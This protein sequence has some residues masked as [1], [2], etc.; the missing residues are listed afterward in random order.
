MDF[1]SFAMLKT[2]LMALAVGLIAFSLLDFFGIKR[3]A[4]SF[5]NVGRIGV[6]LIG[7]LLLGVGMQVNMKI[8]SIKKEKEME[9]LAF[10]K[11]IFLK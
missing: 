2:F 9:N 1:S 11:I 5:A 6:N 7:G 10:Y 4:K 3:K 8:I